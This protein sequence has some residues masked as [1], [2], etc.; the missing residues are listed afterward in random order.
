MNKIK[1]RLKIDKYLLIGIILL[2]SVGLMTFLS[3]SLGILSGNEDK[4]YSLIKSQLFYVLVLSPIVLYISQKIEYT[5]YKKYSYI[6]FGLCLLF[7]LTTL[8]PGLKFSYNGATRWIHIFGLSLQPSE[9]LKIGSVILFSALCIKY[10]KYFSDYKIGLIPFA[11]IWSVI[12]IPILVLQRDFGTFF[13]ILFSSF[14]VYF[15]G[16]AKWKHIG[17]LI[18]LGI[19]SFVLLIEARPYMKDRIITF[20]NPSH[21]ILGSS[22]QLNQ[23]LIAVGAGGVTGRGIG[24]SIQKFNYLP[25]QISDS[26]FAVYAEETGLIGSIILLG[27]YCFIVFRGIYII[28]NLEDN[29]AILLSIGIISILFIQMF[30]NISSVIGIMPLTGVPLPLVSRGGTSLIFIMFELGILLNI[31]KYKRQ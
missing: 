6:I 30:L 21:D 28:K 18:L 24:Q 20:I 3:A 22:Y 17:I 31:S 15:V 14:V 8:I 23:S 16:G 1:S 7:S 29:Y 10:K 19:I 9:F 27:I 12:A 26:I 4:F 5:Y 25:E 11:A 2:M 13:I